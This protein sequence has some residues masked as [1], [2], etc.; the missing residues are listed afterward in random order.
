MTAWAIHREAEKLRKGDEI[1]LLP[2]GALVRVHKVG[3]DAFTV[4]G[5]VMPRRF[6]DEYHP[7]DNPA[8]TWCRPDGRR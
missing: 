5:H 2:A 1:I 4:H 7:T 8:G 6:A 3:K